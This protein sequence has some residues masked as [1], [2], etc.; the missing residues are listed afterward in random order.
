M[1]YSYRDM[2]IMYII[3]LITIKNRIS[4]II[5]ALTQYLNFNYYYY[6]C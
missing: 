4:A 6:K 1:A 2:S 5:F 3:Q